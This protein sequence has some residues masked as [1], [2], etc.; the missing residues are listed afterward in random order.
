MDWNKYF[1]SAFWV[2]STIRIGNSTSIIVHGMKIGTGN[3]DG[4]HFQIWNS[5][6][7]NVG[8]AEGHIAPNNI[9]CAAVVPHISPFNS[10]NGTMFSRRSRGTG[11]T[12]PKDKISHLLNRNRPHTNIFSLPHASE[13]FRNTRNTRSGVKNVKAI[14]HI[15]ETK[16]RKLT[17]EIYRS[18][19]R[20]EKGIK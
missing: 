19:S 7:K 11:T 16:I 1:F 9:L 10:N 17:R 8:A 13:I 12:A 15:R 3:V 20:S 18:F 2:G 4:C 14:F 5:Y 6:A